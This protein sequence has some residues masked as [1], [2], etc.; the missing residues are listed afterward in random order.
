MEIIESEEYEEFGLELQ[1][2]VIQTLNDTLK[3]YKISEKLRKE[4][5]GDFIFDFSMIFDQD[6]I[7]DSTPFIGFLKDEKMYLKDDSFEYHEYAFG[8]TDEFFDNEL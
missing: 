6:E 2:K 8:N 1:C 5:C 4:I 7:L 3:K